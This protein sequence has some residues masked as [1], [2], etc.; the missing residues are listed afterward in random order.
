MN[1]YPDYIRPAAVKQFVEQKRKSGPDALDAPQVMERGAVE[2]RHFL[3]LKV[4][5]LKGKRVLNI[6]SGAGGVFDKDIANKGAEVVSLSPFLADVGPGG[7]IMREAYAPSYRQ[8]AWKLLGGRV[9]SP[10]TVP[11]VAEDLPIADESIDAVLALYSVP[12]YSTDI[13]K[14]T[15]E[16]LRVLAKEGEA[17]LYPVSEKNKALIDEALGQNDEIEIE[18]Q[19]KNEATDAVYRGQKAYLLVIKKLR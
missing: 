10:L 14:M 15:S 5:S 19:E 13:K 7:K 6:G 8:K 18:Y 12:L 1:K 3:D 11:G 17:R 9:S 16:I 2:Y 4:N